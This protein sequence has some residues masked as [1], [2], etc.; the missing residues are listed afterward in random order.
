MFKSIGSNWM[1]ERE[2][3]CEMRTL[4]SL[5][6]GIAEVSLLKIDVQGYEREALAGWMEAVVS[7]ASSILSRKSNRRLLA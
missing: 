1:V 2:V 7:S 3:E 6:A 4:D 5:L